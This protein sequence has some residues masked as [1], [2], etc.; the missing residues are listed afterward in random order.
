[1]SIPLILGGGGGGGKHCSDHHV[2]R[3]GDRHGRHGC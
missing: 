2:G 1:V 3:N